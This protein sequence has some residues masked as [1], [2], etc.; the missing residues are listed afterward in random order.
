MEM[1]G[2]PPRGMVEAASR[3]KMFFDKD[4]NPRIVPNSRGKRRKPGSRDLTSVLHTSY[5]QFISF[6]Q[7]CL[8]WD[9]NSR[10]TP[11][12][13][14]QHPWLAESVSAPAASQVFLHLPSLARPLLFSLGATSPLAC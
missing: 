10:L 2:R 4:C 14:L 5:K 12:Q 1:L 11:E 13:A 3:E 9:K 8:D 7:G 6:L